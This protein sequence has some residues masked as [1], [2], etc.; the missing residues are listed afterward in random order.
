MLRNQKIVHFRANEASRNVK[1]NLIRETRGKHRGNVV[2]YAFGRQ[3]LHRSTFF[4]DGHVREDS[5]CASK[6]VDV[7]DVVGGEFFDGVDAVRVGANKI[8]CAVESEDV[9]DNG[10]RGCEGGKGRTVIDASCEDTCVH[11]G[12]VEFGVIEFRSA[13]LISI[14]IGF[15]R[16]GV[17]VFVKVHCEDNGVDV[18]EEDVRVGPDCI[19]KILRLMVREVAEL[20]SMLSFTMIP[21]LSQRQGQP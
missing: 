1:V 2:R 14:D 4:E 20:M 15:R 21:E 8:D 16:P 11:E 6:M 9:S 3:R 17:F 18:E 5:L 10:E 13:C 12:F 7:L 19:Q